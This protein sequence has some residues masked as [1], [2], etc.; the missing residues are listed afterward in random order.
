MTNTLYYGDN[1]S[2]LREFDRDSVDLIYLD[3]PFNKKAVFNLL[4]RTPDGDAVQ[5]QTAAFKDTWSWETCAANDAFEEAIA[6]NSTVAPI[7][8]GFR[9]FLRQSDMMAYLAMMAVRLVY[10][11]KLLKPTG[12]LYLH[13]DPTACHYLKILLDGVFGPTAFKN[14]I[15][16][17]R[18]S[19]HSDSRTWSRVADNI[20]FYTKSDIF[21]WNIPREPHSE[22]YLRAKYRFTDDDGRIYRLD[23]M[24]SPNPRPNMMYSWKGFPTPGKGWRY[25]EIDDARTG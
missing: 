19:T 16:W 15:V 23:N 7:L 1:L 24:T 2:Y 9:Q 4:F 10:L 11:H 12:S 21:T 5:A 22:K 3:P 14:E 25:E 20:L 13:C 8:R 17:K 6:A 18:T